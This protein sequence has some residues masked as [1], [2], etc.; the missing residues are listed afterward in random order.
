MVDDALLIGIISESVNAPTLAR[1][2]A[3]VILVQALRAQSRN[4][5][6]D[7]SGLDL[8]EELRAL[9]QKFRIPSD[10]VQR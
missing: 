1:R 2:Q 6:A 5:E 8:D 9:I 4:A 7:A 3:A 10:L